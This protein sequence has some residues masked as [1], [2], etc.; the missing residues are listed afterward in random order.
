MRNC[1]FNKI[2]LEK[3]SA[4]IMPEVKV[5]AEGGNGGKDREVVETKKKGFN[6]KVPPQR[7]K[8]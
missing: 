2:K 5:K 8:F 7:A 1:G 3:V 6:F 4:A